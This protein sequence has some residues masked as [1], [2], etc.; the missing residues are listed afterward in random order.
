MRCTT[1]D[2]SPSLVVYN[3]RPMAKLAIDWNPG[4]IGK[5]LYNL[6]PI[7]GHWIRGSNLFASHP[8]HYTDRT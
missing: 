2:Y 1:L 3:K 6:F 4:H 8:L 7:F 5:R